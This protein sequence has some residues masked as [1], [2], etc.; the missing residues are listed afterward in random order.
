MTL[1]LAGSNGEQRGPLMV[2]IMYT[3]TLEQ[4][5]TLAQKWDGNLVPVYREISADLETPVS[6][7][8]KI[9][10]GPHSFLLE[11]VESGERQ[12]R[13]SFIGTE[14]YRLLKTGPGTEAGPIDPLLPIEQ[15]LASHKA[16]TV[17]GLPRFLGGA[18]GYL[19]YECV[20]YFEP[21]VPPAKEDPLGLPESVFMFMDTLLVFDHLHH[22]IRIVSHVHLDLGI[23]EG[24]A[25]AVERI[26]TLALRLEEPLR[27]PHK[28]PV[29]GTPVE[30]TSN[31][32]WEAYHEVVRRCKE[33]IVAGDVIQV[34][35]SQ[36]WARP[37]TAAPFDIYRELRALN[38][39]PYM[40]FLTLDDFYIIGA[41]PEALVTVE[42]GVVRN[43]P[44]AGTRRRGA[45]PEEDEALA[46]ELRNDEKE[47]AEHIMLVDLGRNDVGR[48]SEPGSVEVT[49]LMRVVRY[50]HVMHLESEIHGR[51]R[52]D[53]TIYDALR[54]CMP[55]GTL[56]GAP[57]IRAMEIIAELEP[58]RRGPYGAAVGYFGFQGNMDTAIPIRTIVMKD[59]VAYVQAGGG[60][61]YDSDP[62]AEYQET[63]NKA[64]APL[65]AIAQAEEDG[66][67]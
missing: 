32:D 28:E 52:A 15:E 1:S 60:I 31:F 7:Y 47:R 9:A 33:Y 45:T 51:L 42:D 59:G 3:P 6:A 55:A 22:K 65:R 27:L 17:E 2:S 30:P 43:F 20:S 12:A 36:R 4:V 5:K 37:T 50:S 35:P 64:M 63:V 67:K 8:L 56:S 24:Y 58:E 23:E 29:T 66:G 18:I 41:S 10:R 14:P 38:P 26:E 62:E 39:S 34:V 49:D 11:S 48:V 13:Y 57:K 21:R 40:Y 61:V 25:Q 54:S 53:R 19:A 16:I 46:Q 44:L